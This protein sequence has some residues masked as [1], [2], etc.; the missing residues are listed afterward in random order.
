[1]ISDR[2]FGSRP[3]TRPVPFERDKTIF[4]CAIS[5]KTPKF[6][7]RNEHAAKESG[8]AEF[9]ITDDTRRQPGAKEWARLLSHADDLQLVCV[10]LVE[11]V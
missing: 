10:P 3:I 9:G 6:L 11:E 5:T 8:G 2:H 4:V 7:P 1:M